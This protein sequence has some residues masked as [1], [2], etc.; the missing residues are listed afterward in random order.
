MPDNPGE[1]QLDEMNT[2]EIQRLFNVGYAPAAK[3]RE[4]AIKMRNT[5]STEKPTLGVEEAVKKIRLS[6]ID[7]LVP[8][9]VNGD[10]WEKEKIRPILS[11]VARPG[12]ADVVK[13]L[14]GVREKMKGYTDGEN[15]IQ[16]AEDVDLFFRFTK[17]DIAIATAE[18]G[19]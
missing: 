17:L 7:Y 13:V 4:Y 15:T 1:K 12:K 10:A 18:K 5:R 3:I 11:L 19:E 6:V 9:G 8:S 2:S 16:T 14:E